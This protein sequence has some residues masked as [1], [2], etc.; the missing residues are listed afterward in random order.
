MGPEAAAIVTSAS[1]TVGVAAAGAALLAVASRDRPARA[2]LGAPI[3]VVAALAAGIAVATRSMLVAEDDYRT[4]LFIVL[5][6]SPMAI[7]IGV[8][9]AR[10]VQAME[11][12]AARE[13]AARER[14]AAVE[15][16]RRETITWVTH[17]LRTP[18]SGIRLVAESIHEGVADPATGTSSIMREVDRMSEMVD[19]IAELSRLHGHVTRELTRVAVEDMLSDAVAAI[20]PFAQ[21]E[22]VTLG[23]DDVCH[24]D[25]QVDLPAATRAITNILR[26]AVQHTPAGGSVEL[27]ATQQGNAVQVAVRDECGGIPAADLPRLV[28]PGWQGDAARTGGRGMGLGLAIADEVVRAHGGAVAVANAPDGRGCEVVLTFPVITRM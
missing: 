7:L 20:S 23:V 24:A 18:L 17:D 10:R 27:V 19:D 2:A 26:N 28:E 9:I 5:A 13:R 11:R 6:G 21:A 14:D 4:V 22:G 3:V 1:V 15:A 25:L 8:L 16:S 12:H